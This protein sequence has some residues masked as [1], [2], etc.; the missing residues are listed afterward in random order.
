MTIA[1]APLQRETVPDLQAHLVRHVAE[2]GEDGLHFMPFEPG[3]GDGPIGLVVDRA[4]LSTTAPNWQR[5]FIAAL[6]D[7]TVV[8]HIDIKSHP[9]RTARHRCTLGIGIE[10]P[11]RGAGLGKRL[12]QTAI[13]FARHDPTLEWLDLNVMGG[14]SRAQAL[15]QQLGFSHIGT[16][17]EAFIIQN[18]RI[19][20]LLMTLS[21]RG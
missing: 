1:I 16:I 21:V 13:E 15:Y 5:W 10:K 6:A 2:S 12:M 4:F 19:D 3:A 17:Q 20:D 7:G 8:G 18:T 14:N 11:W 9:L